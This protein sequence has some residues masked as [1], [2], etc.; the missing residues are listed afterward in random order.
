MPDLSGIHLNLDRAEDR[1]K[2]LRGNI[3]ALSER[4]PVPFGFRTQKTP[5]P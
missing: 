5:G 2:T 4:D 1:I 3:L